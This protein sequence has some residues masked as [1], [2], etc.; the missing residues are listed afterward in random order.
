[1]LAALGFSG[2][3]EAERRLMDL[4]LDETAEVISSRKSES[5]GLFAL[6]DDHTMMRS[7]L[8]LHAR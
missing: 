5:I 4:L 3:S 2:Q 7:N 8:L 6:D 1:M